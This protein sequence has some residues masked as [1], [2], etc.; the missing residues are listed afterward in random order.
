MLGLGLEH[1]DLS[2]CRRD[3]GHGAGVAHREATQPA[4]A[5]DRQADRRDRHSY[6][7]R[8]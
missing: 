2:A 1:V 8:H 5:A 7:S 4:R 6:L 3:R